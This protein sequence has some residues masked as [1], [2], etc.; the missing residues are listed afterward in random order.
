M[1]TQRPGGNKPDLCLV[2]DSFL[3]TWVWTH[4]STPAG[5]APPP[6]WQ[7]R[8]TKLK[9]GGLLRRRCHGRRKDRAGGRTRRGPRAYLRHCDHQKIWQEGSHTH[10]LSNSAAWRKTVRASCHGIQHWALPRRSVS[11]DFFLCVFISK[12]TLKETKEILE[13]TQFVWSNMMMNL[14]K[15]DVNPLSNA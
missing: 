7:R 4:A 2:T 5:P 3:A 12:H 11:S 13:V 9:R 1:G 8:R 15:P 6:A 10:T 14:L